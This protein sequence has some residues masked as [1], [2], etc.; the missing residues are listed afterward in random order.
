MKFVLIALIVLC[1]ASVEVFAGNNTELNFYKK[2]QLVNTRT[3]TVV[4]LQSFNDL[5]TSSQVIALID[6]RNGRTDADTKRVI[7]K[8]LENKEVGEKLKQ[9]LSMISMSLEF[10]MSTTDYESTV[11]G[12]Y[13]AAHKKASANFKKNLLEK[14]EFAS[15]AV[16]VAGKKL[17]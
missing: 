7:D 11:L 2:G 12:S 14:A 17:E 5:K 10:D 1:S 15:D 13:L 16:S 9:A 3:M 4:E 8:F 6:K